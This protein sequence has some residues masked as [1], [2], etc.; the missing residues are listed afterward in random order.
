MVQNKKH[1]HAYVSGRVQG[2]F[3]RSTTRSKAKKY[4]ITGWV[5][6]LADGRVELRAEG[7]MEQLKKLE[8]FLHEGPRFAK[9]ENVE[10]NFSEDIQNYGQFRVKR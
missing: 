4:G 5:Q 6:N 7:N 1:M 10:V 2:V 9:V 8:D 3:F